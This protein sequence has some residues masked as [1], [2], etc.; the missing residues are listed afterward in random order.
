MSHGG[1]GRGASGRA[2]DSQAFSSL[3]QK[4]GSTPLRDDLLCSEMI[5]GDDLLCSFNQNLLLAHCGGYGGG[6]TSGWYR[7]VTAGS[8]RRTI[9]SEG[10]TGLT[11]LSG[12][13]PQFSPW[14]GEGSPFSHSLSP[15]LGTGTHPQAMALSTLA[16]TQD[17]SLLPSV[18]ATPLPFWKCFLYFVLSF[19]PAVCCCRSNLGAHSLY[20]SPGKRRSSEL[21]GSRVS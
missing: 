17:P 12:K 10:Q 5:Y 14:L 1:E 21:V 20:G 18:P 3:F 8:P 6:H 13:G 4:L 16:S 15:K 7:G 19:A 2:L 11:L 9:W